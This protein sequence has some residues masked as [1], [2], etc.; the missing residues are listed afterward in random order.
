[1][2]LAEKLLE[3]N[4]SLA[5]GTSDASTKYFTFFISRRALFLGNIGVIE[6]TKSLLWKSYDIR[7]KGGSMLF[8]RKSG[9][10]IRTL[11]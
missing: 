2:L 5:G 11:C 1:M 10:T 6:L 9:L 3:I 8:D 7:A 4:F